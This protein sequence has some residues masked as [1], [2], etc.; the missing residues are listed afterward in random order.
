MNRKIGKL[1]ALIG[2]TAM[3]FASG[4]AR[5]ADNATASATA[6]VIAPIAVSKS[7]DM[8]FGNVLAGNG[9]VTLS[10]SGGRTQSG[11]TA[12][13]TS[14]ST[15][16]A[17][18]FDVTGS[19]SNTFSIDY[20]GS[21]TVLTST[22]DSGDTMAVDWIVE[23]VAG[24][25]AATGKTD[26]TTDA[27]SGTLSSGNARIYAGGQLTVGASQDTGTY[28]GSLKVTVAYN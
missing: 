16:T 17:A 26:E 21:D 19:G 18:R 2:L 15:A 9:V 20:T 10:T 3:A 7:T 5:A 11:S 13:S 4:S 12:L 1:T 27:T 6:L 24:T 28:T 22:T 14:G 23:A 8:V 25:G